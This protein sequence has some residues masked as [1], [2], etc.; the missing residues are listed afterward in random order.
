MSAANTTDTSPAAAATEE[1]ATPEP[2]AIRTPEPATPQLVEV[3]T[4]AITPVTEPIDD[5]ELE[6]EGWDRTTSTSTSISTS[7]YRH[8]WENGRRFHSYKHGRYPIPNDDIEQNREDIKHAMMLEITDGKLYYAPLSKNA[9]KIIDFLVDDAEEEWMNGD[10][11]DLVHM[12]SMSSVLKDIPKVLRHSYSALKPG[13]WLEMQELQAVLH[14][15]DDT[16]PDD[17]GLLQYYKTLN[18]ALTRFGMDLEMPR[19]LRSLLEEAGFVNIHHIPKKVPVGP[20]ASDRYLRVAGLY[21]R[22]AISHLIPA[23]T[24]KSFRALGLSE[25]ECEMIAMSARQALQD[26]SR[27]R[28]LP[29]HFWTA[30]KPE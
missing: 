21:L 2:T 20:W 15:D 1:R 13:G 16:M 18:S 25:A 9:Q 24:S 8:S 29:F 12:R 28:Y 27:H 19:K 4:P 23:T 7:I 3:E 10:N 14:C 17:D 11:Y 6:I 30:Q 26:M 22:E 5:E